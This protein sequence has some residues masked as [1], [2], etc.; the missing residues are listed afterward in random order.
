MI[1]AD[2]IKITD[3]QTLVWSVGHDVDGHPSYVG[4]SKLASFPYWE[5]HKVFATYDAARAELD[6]LKAE[7]IFAGD[8]HLEGVTPAE[9]EDYI[10]CLYPHLAT[11]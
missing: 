7:A 3:D 9:V 10:R 5:W 6:R 8:V 4:T 2:G 11:E 1:T